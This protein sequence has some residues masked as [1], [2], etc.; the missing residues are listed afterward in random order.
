MGDRSGRAV[1]RRDL[2]KRDRK[3]DMEMK[4]EIPL[5]Y[6]R[7]KRNIKNEMMRMMTMNNEKEL[8]IAEKVSLT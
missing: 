6:V 3:G 4:Y 8:N 1:P 5:Y 7:H 2:Q